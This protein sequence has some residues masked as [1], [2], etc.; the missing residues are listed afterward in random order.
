L[1]AASSVLAWWWGWPALAWKRLHWRWGL[2]GY[3]MLTAPWFV[4][5]SVASSGD[6][7]RFAVGRQIVH[8]FA[9]DME[10]HGGFPGYYAV[11]SALVFYPWSALV[12]AALVGAWTRRKSDPNLGFLLAWTIGPLLLLECFRTKLIHY[13]L[14]AIPACALLATWLILSVTA[15]GVNIRRRPLG[16]LGIALLIGVGLAGIVLLLAGTTL[17]AA[18]LRPPL[19]FLAAV[20]AVGTLAGTSFFQQGAT[21]RAVYSLAATWAIATMTTSGWLIPIGEPYRTS[22][23]LGEK[24]A[25]LAAKLK[26]EPVLLE[27][28]E[29][30]MVYSLGYPIALTRDRAGFYSHLTGGRWVLTVA[31]PSEI[32]VMRRHFGLEVTPLDQ[33]S[34]FVV[35]KGNHQILQLAVVRE[36]DKAPAAPALDPHLRRVGLKLEQTT[37]K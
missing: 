14:P 17:V 30:G 21:E 8:R 32:D 3:S 36:G 37:V 6:F 10:S 15:E 22:R 19:L 13:Y 25:A 18:D 23:V 33:V 16:R 24:L 20:I 27:Y 4:A 5:I 29:P 26:V 11:V 2:L 12:P 35:A 1:I 9:S 7:L 34:T 31:L 28:Q